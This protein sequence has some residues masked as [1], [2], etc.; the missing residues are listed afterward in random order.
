MFL[1]L[2]QSREST[3]E[4]VVIA[5]EERF[6]FCDQVHRVAAVFDEKLLGKLVL[7]RVHLPGY[8]IGKV[9]SFLLA[10]CRWFFLVRL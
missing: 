10:T 4:I 1:E 3:V 8:F 6:I 9:K 2:A 5:I 7:I